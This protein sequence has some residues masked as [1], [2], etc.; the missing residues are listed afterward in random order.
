MCYI[1]FAKTEGFPH[2]RQVQVPTFWGSFMR[3]CDENSSQ[4]YHNVFKEV[5][6]GLQGTQNHQDH[7]GG[8]S[9][10]VRRTSL[11]CPPPTCE[12]SM[13]LQGTLFY[14]EK[15]RRNS[16]SKTLSILLCIIVS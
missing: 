6:A 9:L 1:I 11:H 14:T 7:Q 16:H 3:L 4:S 15:I 8:Y 13:P 10:V 12:S 5:F 2:L